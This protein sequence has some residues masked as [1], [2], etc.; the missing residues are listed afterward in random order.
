MRNQLV[1]AYLDFVNNYFTAERYAE[2]NGLTVEQAVK[3][4]DLAREVTNSEHP[5]A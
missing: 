4:L 1:K 3:L 5:D 2:C